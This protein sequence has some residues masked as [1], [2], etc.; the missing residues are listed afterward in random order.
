M[1]GALTPGVKWP[2]SIMMIMMMMKLVVERL[3]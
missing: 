1:N 3:F 2:A